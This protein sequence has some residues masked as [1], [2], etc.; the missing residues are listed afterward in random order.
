MAALC[1]DAA[2]AT[3]NEISANAVRRAEQHPTGGRNSPAGHVAIEPQARPYNGC[4]DC[5]T[6]GGTKSRCQRTVTHATRK[7]ATAADKGVSGTPTTGGRPYRG[8]PNLVY[9]YILIQL[10]PVKFSQI[11]VPLR[12]MIGRG[13]KTSIS[14]F[15][16]FLRWH[17]DEP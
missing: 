17:G 13:W 1:R 5:R 9:C 15:Q 16:I 6:G 4:R 8:P 12:K 2:T 14:G 11:G 10:C 7:T 3:Q